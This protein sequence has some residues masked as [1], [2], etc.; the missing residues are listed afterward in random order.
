[1]EC[2]LD[3]LV[4]IILIEVL[5]NSSTTITEIVIKLTN[6]I[7]TAPITI[8]RNVDRGQ[9]ISIKFYVPITQVHK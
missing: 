9:K 6:L 7:I 8:Y 2:L 4:G 5:I 1:M 3:N